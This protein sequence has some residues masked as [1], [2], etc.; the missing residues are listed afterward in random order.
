[1]IVMGMDP[2]LATFGIAV[3]QRA[4]RRTECLHAEVFTSPCDS[5]RPRSIDRTIRAQRLAKW[6]AERVDVYRPQKF[7]AEAMS[8]P[9]GAAAIASICLA[10]GVIAGESE[11]RD[12]LL[13]E[14][15]PD[16]W[17]DHL[18]ATGS[19]TDEREAAAHRICES[20]VSRLRSRTLRYKSNAVHALDAAGVALWTLDLMKGS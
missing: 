9:R 14:I 10:W 7:A 2:G 12:L 20:R 11:R 4:H 8:F 3:L 15:R 5:N 1:M 16:V 17:R 6:L 19:T 13:L 18:G